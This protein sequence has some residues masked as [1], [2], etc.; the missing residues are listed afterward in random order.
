LVEEFAVSYAY[1]SLQELRNG[2]DIK[3]RDLDDEQLLRISRSVSKTMDKLCGRT[4]RTYNATRIYSPKR[5][6][7]IK[8]DDLLSVTSIKTDLNYDGVYEV[9][10]ATTDYYLEPINAALDQE[11]YTRVRLRT[12]G[13]QYLPY[14]Y[15][16]SLEIVGKWGYWEELE[17]VSAT[18][19][20]VASSTAIEITISAIAD[21]SAGNTILVGTEQ[22]YVKARNA[23]TSVLTV[24]RAVNNTTAAAIE[25][26]AA[27]RVYR[28]PEPVVSATQMLVNRYHARIKTPLGMVN[29]PGDIG[30][31]AIYIPKRDID[32]IDMLRH[33]QKESWFA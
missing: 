7:T 10:W 26:G 17:L 24:E 14:M 19:Q 1:V 4:F 28:Y 20:D 29:V 25:A 23:T 11:P 16:K 6:E 18:V 22:L 27:I 13:T 2:L 3:E 33:Y 15:E 9:T 12:G 8:I 21:I 5:T 32:V 30:W 31:R